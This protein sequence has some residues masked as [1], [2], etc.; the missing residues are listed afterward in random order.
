M[1]P[2]FFSTSSECGSECDRRRCPL[3]VHS[4][5][6]RSSGKSSHVRA[7][8]ESGSQFRKLAATLR[9]VARRICINHSREAQLG[10]TTVGAAETPA[11]FAVDILQHQYIGMDIGLVEA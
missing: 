11:E 6:G 3:R 1:G 7:D 9:A 10:N 2:K 4:P 5:P 8:A